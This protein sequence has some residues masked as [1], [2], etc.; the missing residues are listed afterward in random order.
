VQPLYP[1]LLGGVRLLVRSGDVER[2]NEVLAAAS[3]NVDPDR[4]A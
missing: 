2:A 4:S 3:D 1:Q